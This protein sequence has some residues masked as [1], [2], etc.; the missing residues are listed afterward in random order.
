MNEE[1]K[2]GIR[3]ARWVPP[4]VGILLVILVVFTSTQHAPTVRLPDGTEFRLTMAAFTN[5][6]SYTRKLAPAWVLRYSKFIPDFIER[7]L[8]KGAGTIGMGS[9]AGTN[10]MV[11][12]DVLNT[13]GRPSRISWLRIRDTDD[14]A[15]ETYGQRGEISSGSAFSQI[16]VVSELPRRTQKLQ[17]EPLVML[18]DGRWTNIGPFQIANP[19]FGKFPQWKPKPLPQARTNDG[20]TAT[21][22]KLI[23]GSPTSSVAQGAP[24]SPAN[25]RSTRMEFSFSESGKPVDHYR[26]HHLAIADATGNKWSPYLNINGGRGGWSTNGATEFLGALWPGEDAWKIELQALRNADFAETEIW[27]P[28]VIPLPNAQTHD[29]LTNRFEVDGLSIHLAN[30]EA[31]GVEVTDSWQSIV[32]YWGQESSVYALGVMFDEDMRDR[33]LVLVGAEDQRGKPFK[34]VEQRGADY[35][36]QALFLQAPNGATELHLKLAFPKL[37]KF[38]YLAHPK[39]IAE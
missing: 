29:D 31:P 34:L 16:W 20:L 15:F 1:T 6:Y 21:L 22:T 12:F 7:R 14:N 36:Q 9:P 27:S 32:R 25:P 26:I 2:R 28:P 33:R 23:A 10:L 30:I 5:S 18:P 37:K 13:N 39:F 24:A 19:F 8:V 11:A 38:E 35:P 4:F 17:L 3:R